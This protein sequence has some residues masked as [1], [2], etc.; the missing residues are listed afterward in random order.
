MILQMIDKRR[1][2]LFVM[3]NYIIYIYC[4]EDLN[5]YIL[6]S[7]NVQKCILDTISKCP[8]YLFESNKYSNDTI[9]I[10]IL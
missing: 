2:L 6:L 3:P 9:I 1:G 7:C 4:D 8:G 5:T 10:T